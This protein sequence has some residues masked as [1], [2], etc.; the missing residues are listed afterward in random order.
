[1]NDARTQDDSQSMGFEVMHTHCAQH[2]AATL[3]A[4]TIRIFDHCAACTRH[5]RAGDDIVRITF[6]EDGFDYMHLDCAQSHPMNAENHSASTECA[7]AGQIEPAS[8]SSQS[9]R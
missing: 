6:G 2:Y 1:M 4:G 7:V 8:D 5:F 9:P 3:P